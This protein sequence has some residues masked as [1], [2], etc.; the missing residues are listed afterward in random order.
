MAGEKEGVEEATPN[1]SGRYSPTFVS[2]SGYAS[3]VVSSFDGQ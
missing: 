2:I 3:T 1:V